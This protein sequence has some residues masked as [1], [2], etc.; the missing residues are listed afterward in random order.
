MKRNWGE[1]G[2]GQRREE[3]AVKPSGWGTDRYL[4][5]GDGMGT[6]KGAIRWG[7]REERWAGRRL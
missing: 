7:G 6:G 5:E 2:V 4:I 3:R 1:R